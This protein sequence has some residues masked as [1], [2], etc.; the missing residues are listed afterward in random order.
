LIADVRTM[1]LTLNATPRLLTLAD[2]PAG[3]RL[4]EA[5]GWNQ[6]ETDWRNL[7]DLAPESC[8]GIDC[9][10]ELRATTTAICYG[11]ELAWIGMVLTEPAYRGL[12][13]ARRLIEHTLEHLRR[14]RVQ[15]IKLDATDMGRPVYARLGFRDETVIERWVR[16]PGRVHARATLAGRFAPDATLDREAFG[17]DRRPLLRAL[18][19]IESASIAD[20]GFGMGRAGSV[21]SYFGPCVA[22]SQDAARDLLLW[23]LNR[24]GGESIY[25]DILAANCEAVELA[26]EFGFERAREL[27]RMTLAGAD[28]ATPLQNNDALV[29]AAAGFEYG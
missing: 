9:E 17:A 25:W 28:H 19:A 3:M 11:R 24:H 18:G 20:T 16:K 5:A 1:C 10:D 2:I 21:A 15:W 29:F 23:F 8:F 13:L 6:T 4:K 14:E 27:T 26:R 12:G 22:R 7:L